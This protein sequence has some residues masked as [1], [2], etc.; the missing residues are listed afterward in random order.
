MNFTVAYRGR[1]GVTGSAGG[2]AL[3]FAPNL[4]RDRVSFAG[5]LRDPLGFREAV[6]AL[7]AVVVGDLKLK[8]KDRSAYRAYLKRVQERE[9][10][11]RGLA[12]R[13]AK[14][15]LLAVEPEP[16][17]PGLKPRFDELRQR[18]WDARLRYAG[19]LAKNDPALF[20]VLVPCD[21]V[22][23]VAPDV[24]FFECFSKDESSYGCLTVDRDRFAAAGDV[25]IGTTNVDYSLG[26]YEEFQRLRTYRRT[27]FAVDPA[28]FEVSTEGAADYGE[29]KID[30]P[31]SWLRGFMQLQ[32]AMSLP[33]RRVPVSREGLYSILAHLKRRRARTSP[34]A[35]R[36]ELTPGRPVQI[37]LE[38]W[39][40][41]I[42]LHDTPYPG[43]RVEVVRTWGR[44]RLLALARLLPLADGA[45][46]FLLGNGLPSF[47]SVR[48]GGMRFLLGLSGWT[49]N[50]WTSGG[51]ALA[52]L[53]PPAEP[54]E[55]LLGDIA[56]A[57]R[58]SPALSFEQV[59]QR[60]GGAPHLVAAGLNR[61]ALLGQV[62][63]DLAGGVYRWRQILP[64]EASL[65]QVA[66]DSPEAASARDLVARGLV[67]VTRDE[68]VG[69]LRAIVGRVEHKEIE[70]V[71]DADR[72]I[73]RGR[74]NCSHYFRFKLRAGPC[75]HMQ[76]LRRAADGARPA[77]TLE[78]WYQM[79][80]G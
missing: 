31:P 44:D 5:D 40:V 73:V 42:T 8:P 57:F 67:T 62:I 37:V 46:V 51:G 39:E 20:R 36:F 12:F 68:T 52:D 65:K 56:D 64:V 43:P 71:C 13:A 7:H 6:S 70:V 49:A 14:E 35:L 60:T 47:W 66:I 76:A 77:G 23:T 54:S 26:L 18:Y 2:M 63:H 10:A 16:V 27:R 45:D 50:D 59:R 32:A 17:P 11:I 53:A 48:M 55:D 15:Q 33:L 61:F 22:V 1:S 30:L 34:R 69:G 79:L 28:G 3:S 58:A 75:R 78:R 25:A 21:P 72:R 38:P 19:Y 9:Q 29:E 24:L 41:R 80:T 4:R 74:C